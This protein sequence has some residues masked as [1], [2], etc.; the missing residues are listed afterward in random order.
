MNGQPS[1]LNTEAEQTPGQIFLEI[2]SDEAPASTE[3]EFVEN[4]RMDVEVVQSSFFFSDVE[5][6]KPHS[7]QRLSKI[8]LD[9]QFGSDRNLGFK[10]FCMINITPPLQCFWFCRNGKT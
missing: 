1:Q 4:V 5:L 6:V 8:S 9:I 7:T 2:I 10:D 3:P